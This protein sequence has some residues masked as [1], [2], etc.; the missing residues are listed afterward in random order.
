MQ[1]NIPGSKKLSH[2]VMAGLVAPLLFVA[3][4]ALAQDD[5]ED[6]RKYDDIETQQRAAVGR[7]CAGVLEEIQELTEEE[8]AWQ[9]ARRKLENARDKCQS[10]YEKSQVYNFLGYIYYSLERYEDAID[11]YT[12]MIQEEEVDPKQAINTRYT[13]AQLYLV[14]EDYAN[15]AEQLELWMEESPNVGADAK[16]LLAQA[17]YQLE[18]K[19]DA[20]RLVEEAISDQEAKDKLPKE[21]WWSLQRVLYYEKGEYAEV[22][23]ILKKLIKHYPSFSYWRQLGGMYGELGREMDQ[24]VATEMPYLAGDMTEERSLM[25]LAYMYLGADVPFRAARII[26]QG[27]DNGHIERNGDNLEVLGQAWQQGQDNSKA[28]PVL[29]EAARALD[30]GDIFARLAGVYLDLDQNQKAV[31]AARNAIQ[32]GDLNR[33]DM[34]YMNMGNALLNL[35][36]YE[37]AIDAFREAADFEDSEKYAKRWIQY[38]EKEGDR[39]QRLIESGADIEGCQ[40]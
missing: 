15:A 9:E 16:V 32:R 14:T 13:I 34:A 33:T 40:L 18:R 38:A 31:S 37:E 28:L 21:G 3:G 26:E 2:R 35:H 20:L 27:M 24:L 10:S 19:D 1:H 4:A 29:E 8:Q 12:S 25:S 11:A 5:D 17:Y 36:C 7:Q 30:E 22:V 23:E 39:R 6:E